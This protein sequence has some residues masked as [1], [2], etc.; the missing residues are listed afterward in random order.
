MKAS[1]VKNF[2]VQSIEGYKYDIINNGNIFNNK[3]DAIKNTISNINRRI[4]KNT[5]YLELI[6]EDL[7]EQEEVLLYYIK[8]INVLILEAKEDNINIDDIML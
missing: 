6:R 5:I 7:R 8:K 1:E 4:A 3:E 2:T